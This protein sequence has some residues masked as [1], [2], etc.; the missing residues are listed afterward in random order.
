LVDDIMAA[1]FAIRQSKTILARAGF[2]DEM[3]W[4]VAVIRQSNDSSK[5]ILSG[6]SLIGVRRK[7]CR[8]R[9]IAL[10]ATQ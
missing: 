4:I 7:A 9:V 3:L 2:V 6:R 5:M 1:S 10:P 8:D